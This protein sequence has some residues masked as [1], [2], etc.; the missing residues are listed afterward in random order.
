MTLDEWQAFVDTQPDRTA[1]HHRQWVELLMEQ[2]G[3]KVF[4]PSIMERG[5]VRAAIPFLETSS[6]YG[7]RHLV[8]LPFTDY[9]TVLACDAEAA[10]TLCAALQRSPRPHVKA[11]IVRTDHPI[12]G[13][14]AQSTKVRHTL[15][16][17]RPISEIEA[18]FV[19]AHTR[20]LRRTRKFRLEFARRTDADAM[21]TYY[22]L[23]LITRAK[24]GVPAQPK[25]FFHRLYRR[26]IQSNLGFIG[27]V[28]KDSEPIAA[29]VF[30]IYHN[31]MIFKFSAS[32]PHALRYGP[33]DFLVYNSIKLAVEEGYDWFDFGVSD[34][35]QGGLRRFKRKFGA[36]ES[37]VFYNY[38]TGPVEPSVNESRSFRFAS[39][40]IRV[41]PSIVCR[42][43]GE[44]FYKYSQ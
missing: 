43:L 26:M 4:L 41:S 40:L 10:A 14:E 27:V 24:L 19:P 22:R 25:R 8:S 18:S 12:R 31:R 42:A 1:M 13:L 20:N 17:A 28:T 5:Q 30:L 23:H 7:T 9:L 44:A 34:K 35:K 11:T 37:D 39:S 16:T 3:L 15:F 6:L 38:V 33:N 32:H 21:E 29:A 2:Y 36:T